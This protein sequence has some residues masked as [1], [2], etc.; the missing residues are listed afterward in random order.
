METFEI[1]NDIAVRTNGDIYVGVVGPVRTGKSTFIKKFMEGLV[2]PTMMNKNEKERTIDELPQSGAGKTVM[3]TQPKFVPNESAKV[4]LADNVEVNVRLVDC[5][6]YLIDGVQ[7]HTE[8]GKPRMVKTPW[9]VEDIP[10]E[11]AAEIGTHKVIADHATIG[12]VVTTDGSI[13][14]LPRIS[15][16]EAEERVVKELKRAEKPFVVVLNSSKPASDPTEKLRQTLQEKYGVPVVVVDVL[17]MTKGQINK[18]LET[19]LYEFPIQK[20]NFE[21][22]Q[23]MRTLGTESDI[24]GGIITE[25]GLVVQTIQ[26]MSDAAKL[27]SMFSD[28]NQILSPVLDAIHLDN[29][30]IDVSIGAKQELFYKVLSDQCGTDISDDF[31]LM[32]YIK[33]LAHAKKEYDKIKTALDDVAEKGYGVV[34]PSIEEMTL[35]E[36]EIIKKGSNSGVRLKAS[37][38][39]L[40]IMKVD[41]R[42]EVCP[43]VGSAWQ[44]EELAKYLLSEFENNPQ[45]IWETNMFGKS[46]S[47]LVREGINGKLQMLPVEAQVKMRKTLAKIV[48]EGKGG[49]ICILL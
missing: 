30:T 48:N 46:L 41:V 2:L 13:T 45:G 27:T 9:S 8:A 20:V 35:E 16:V 31:H 42:T 23:W 10:F 40:H 37:A 11:K 36:P 44:T 32:S 47:M 15:Y 26:K 38:P 17:N 24:I 22:P 33:L 6:G 34:M 4:K 12:V 5:V 18:L 19:V 1:Y 14:D 3:T 29:G 25:I 21:I 28:N 43:A 49:I 39:S 7:G